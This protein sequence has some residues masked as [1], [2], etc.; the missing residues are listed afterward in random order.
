MSNYKTL[1]FGCDEVEQ[2]DLIIHNVVYELTNNE[3]LGCLGVHSHKLPLILKNANQA[4][5]INSTLT[6]R[7]LSKSIIYLAGCEPGYLDF[8]CIK[9]LIK[10]LKSDH[11]LGKECTPS[12][13]I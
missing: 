8:L 9:E 5:L 4:I 3:R 11:I 1:R 13:F 12:V 2:V 10:V 7:H 6:L